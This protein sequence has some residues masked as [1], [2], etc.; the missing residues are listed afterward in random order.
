MGR[1][2]NNTAKSVAAHTQDCQYGAVRTRVDILVFLLQYS[3]IKHQ[4]L[5]YKTL[6]ERTIDAMSHNDPDWEPRHPA[7]SVRRAEGENEVPAP[8]AADLDED[9]PGLT[10]WIRGRVRKGPDGRW[11]RDIGRLEK[12]VY[13]S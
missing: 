6:E 7:G 8:E 1:H 2:G 4:D 5:D 12:R 10:V 9:D 13:V 11:K 3:R